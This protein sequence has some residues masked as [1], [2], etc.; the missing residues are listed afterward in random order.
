MTEEE[1]KA[2]DSCPGAEGGRD[3]SVEQSVFLCVKGETDM[4]TTCDRYTKGITD[5]R[6]FNF[7]EFIDNT[8]RIVKQ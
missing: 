6:L 5:N 2:R 3:K 4:E 8:S 1:L 7:D